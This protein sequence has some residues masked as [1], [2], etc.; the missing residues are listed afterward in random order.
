MSKGAAYFMAGS[1]MIIASQSIEKLVAQNKD[2]AWEETLRT[3][4]LLIGSG[5]II[6]PFISAFLGARKDKP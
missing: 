2:T 6:S 3:A 1:G 4:A 5:M